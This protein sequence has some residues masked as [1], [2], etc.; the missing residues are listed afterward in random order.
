MTAA[1]PLLSVVLTF[2]NE[3]ELLP[4]LIDRLEKALA[5]M[6]EGFELIFVDDASSDGS[7]RLLDSYADRDNRIK[8]ITTSRRFGQAECI[9]AGME[10]T[11]GQAV[12]TMDADLQDPPELIPELVARWKEGAEV[13]Y[14][15]RA[16]RQAESRIRLRLT[17]FAYRL[18]HSLTPDVDL[19][20]EAGDFKL[21]SRRVLAHLLSLPEVDPYPRGMIPWIGFKQVPVSYHRQPRAVGESHFPIFR[22]FLRDLSTL[23]G[24]LGT[25][26]SGLTSY[27][28]MPLMLILLMGLALS[29][30]ALLAVLVAA[31]AVLAGAP[32]GAVCWLGLGGALSTGLELLAIGVV[33][34]YLGRVFRQSRGRPRVIV[35]STRNLD[36][37]RP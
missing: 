37:P 2:R 34:V 4:L 28:I 12:V 32:P 33:G 20:V 18:I 30:V 1:R 26:V 27:S 3:K 19:A 15:V 9:L 10:Y 14:T 31:A 11:A 21:I 17:R 23:H 35:D 6:A 5:G 22:N 29:A 16:S 13:V 24:P 25:L 7:R 36:R 8:I